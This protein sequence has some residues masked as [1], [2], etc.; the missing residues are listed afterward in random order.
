MFI[1]F[2][3][4]LSLFIISITIPR[5]CQFMYSPDTSLY[6]C[7]IWA[8]ARPSLRRSLFGHFRIPGIFWD[9]IRFS[10]LEFPAAVLICIVINSP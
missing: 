7:E 5:F 9:F 8:R 2:H 1:I 4:C 3:I 10:F 6:I